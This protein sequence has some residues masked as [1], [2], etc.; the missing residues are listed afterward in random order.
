MV[1]ASLASVSMTPDS[2]ELSE[3]E[4]V[5]IAID[6]ET[7]KA[8]LAKAEPDQEVASRVVDPDRKSRNDRRPRPIQRQRVDGSIPT[9][10]AA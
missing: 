3:G 10:K 1:L 2:D 4:K 9:A 6:I 7:F 5:D 8:Q